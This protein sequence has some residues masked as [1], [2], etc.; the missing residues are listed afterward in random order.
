M[1]ESEKSIFGSTLT[2]ETAQKQANT[3]KGAD[4]RPVWGKEK[5]A[6]TWDSEHSV[7]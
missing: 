6:V 5:L 3:V 4:G 1:N 2:L 7:R